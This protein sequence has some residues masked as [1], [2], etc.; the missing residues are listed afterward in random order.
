MVEVLDG[1]ADDRGV[2]YLVLERLY[3]LP[4]E[5]VLEPPLS[6]RS[7]LEALVPVINALA[8]CMV[9]ESFT[10]TSSHRTFS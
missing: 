10:A 8:R 2:P 6:L 3:G 9:L 7:T 1:G 5:A 4:L